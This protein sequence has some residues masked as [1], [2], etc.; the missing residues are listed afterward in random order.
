MGINE[1]MKTIFPVMKI[2][3][4]HLLCIQ[5]FQGY[6][7]NDVFVDNFIKIVNSIYSNLN[8]E[9]K[10]TSTCDDICNYCPHNLKGKCKKIIGSSWVIKKKD[11]RVMKNLNIAEGILVKAKDILSLVN[12]RIS[13]ANEAKKICRNC[14]WKEKC[15][16]FISRE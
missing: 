6:G 4:H 1:Q 16:W 11:K 14:S 15:L 12:N 8:G 7:Y 10:I 3:A 5:G 13:K 9:I 2:R